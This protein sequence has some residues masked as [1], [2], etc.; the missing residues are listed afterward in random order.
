MLGDSRQ[1]SS[2]VRAQCS[3]DKQFQRGIL[4]NATTAVLSQPGMKDPDVVMRGPYQSSNRTTAPL[5]ASVHFSMGPSG[6]ILW[7]AVVVDYRDMRGRQL[8]G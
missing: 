1:E 4:I 5:D 6:D 7:V 8:P 2:A 3:H